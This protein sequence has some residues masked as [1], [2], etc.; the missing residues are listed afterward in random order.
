MRNFM[1]EKKIYCGKKYLEV[2]IIPRTI[3]QEKTV[4]GKRAKR[5]KESEPKQKNLNDKNSKRYITQ[6]ANGNFG[7]GDLHVTCTYK[8]K[9]LPE[10]PEEAEKEVSNFFRRL[11]HRRKK[12]GLESLKYIL[13]TEYIMSDENEDKPIRIHHHILMNKG[14]S[15]DEVEEL[16]SKRKKKG[17][18]EGDTIGFINADRLQPN[19]NGLE[20]IS[21][22]I[23][24]SRN[25]KKGK[26]RWSSSRNLIRPE[27][28]KNDYK[29]SKRKIEKLIKE[30][31]FRF[32]EEQYKGYRVVEA[33]PVYQDL[34]G[35]SVYL[36]MWKKE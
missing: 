5:T 2:D 8:D 12:K 6:L 7:K 36:K 13:V 10:T 30:N 24:K 33:S 17:E 29:Y 3:W 11:N 16:W 15:R 4:K 18:K 26:K 20:G 21:R 23:T 1:R 35:W 25:N 31:D 27:S 22:Y 14:L 34:L 19:E 9:Y 32:W 28:I